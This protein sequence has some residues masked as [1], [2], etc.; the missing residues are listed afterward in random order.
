[1]NKMYFFC[2]T[3][4]DEASVELAMDSVELPVGDFRVCTIGDKY[5]IL[6][7]KDYSV[8]E[9]NTLMKKKAEM[10]KNELESA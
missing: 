5:F 6:S 3:Q 4:K 1:M 2:E 8:I 10:L 7:Y 9:D